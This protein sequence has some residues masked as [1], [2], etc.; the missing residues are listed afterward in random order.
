VGDEEILLSDSTE[1]EK[2][3]LAAGVEVQLEV[4]QG[5]WHVFQVAAPLVPESRLALRHIESFL[6]QTVW[7]KKKG[8]P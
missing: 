8:N 3:L 6:D 1:L 4:W 5:M 7:T 2:A